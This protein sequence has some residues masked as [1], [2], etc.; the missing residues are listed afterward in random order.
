MN[1]EGRSWLADVPDI[2]SASWSHIT[3]LCDATYCLVISQL[4]KMFFCEPEYLI[5]PATLATPWSLTGD[6]HSLM[7]PVIRWNSWQE[8]HE[9]VILKLPPMNNFLLSCTLSL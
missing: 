6:E 3:F 5:G 9:Y 8:M 7:Q 4:L 1:E 2:G